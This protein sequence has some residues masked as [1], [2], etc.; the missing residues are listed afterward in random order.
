MNYNDREQDRDL[1]GDQPKRENSKPEL[2]D[3]EKSDAEYFGGGKSSAEPPPIAPKKSI[4]R[5]NSFGELPP[6]V[7]IPPQPAKQEQSEPTIVVSRKSIEN[8]MNGQPSGEEVKPYDKGAIQQQV[9]ARPSKPFKLNIAD[10]DYN[11]IPDF[12]NR[13]RRQA[14]HRA[15]PPVNVSRPQTP[16]KPVRG[17]RPKGEEA[18]DYTPPQ[19]TGAKDAAYR[20]PRNKTL[21]GLGWLANGI[22][23]T[24][25]V[26]F[27]SILL[28]VF[29]LQ[30]MSDVLGLFK[31]EREISVTIPANANTQQV[32]DLLK[33]KGIISQP[34]TF[35]LYSTF[36][37]YADSFLSGSFT[38]NSNMGYDEIFAAI[39]TVRDERQIVTITFIE[40]MT[41][42]EIADKLEEKR[43]CSAED[44]V[45]ALNTTDFGY[46]FEDLIPTGGNRYLK[47]EGYLFPDT[48][49]F[50]VPERPSSVADK[51]LKNF[52]KKITADL[53]DR[54]EKVGMTLDQTI[55]LASLIQKEGRT[56][57][58]MYM[59]S[60]VFHNRLNRPQTFP[61]LQS[62]VTINY[63]NDN[64][65]PF[66]TSESDRE[67]YASAYNTYK[68]DGLPVGPVSNP[69]LNAIKAAIYP[70]DYNYYY[71][72]TDVKMQYYYAQTLAQHEANMARAKAVGDEVGGV[73]THKE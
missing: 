45:H 39:Q 53:I 70:D 17:Q 28:S 36:R 49:S 7:E 46:E 73:N 38:L 24:V 27:V 2:F 71:F 1:S 40:G 43:V 52:N 22:I 57:D 29:I 42:R 21:R 6:D 16:G 35:R 47:L 14:D 19:Q 62:D 4:Y 9:P 15:V 56:L 20:S 72:L 63:V 8:R 54:M 33:E 59:V 48:Y 41:I 66:V 26:L 67:A 5:P 68:C 32:A 44:F 11:A 30:S 69:G 58:D 55:N 61:K 64:I 65:T 60:S 13:A 3:I 31:S 18:F 25:G 34:L 12:D 37:D 10:E 50:F 23:Y 51:F